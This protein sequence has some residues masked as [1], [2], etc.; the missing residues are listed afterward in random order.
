M[1]GRRTWRRKG[2]KQYCTILF[3]MSLQQYECQ[4]PKANGRNF[5]FSQRGPGR[6][7][8]LGPDAVSCVISIATFRSNTLPRIT[9]HPL[10]MALALCSESLVNL[11]ATELRHISY[12]GCL[13]SKCRQ[14]R[15]G[16]MP[17]E[18]DASGAFVLLTLIV[19]MW[20]IGW[21]PNNATK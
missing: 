1:A 4:I 19:L 12:Y 5:R 13:T 18:C 20:R 21:A 9:S 3:L 2:V 10:K 11:K 14:A 15:G 6:W 8:S 7:M 16:G 17:A